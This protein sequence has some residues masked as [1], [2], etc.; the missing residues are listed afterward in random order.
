L[1][2]TSE[3]AA[4]EPPKVVDPQPGCRFRDRCPLAIDLC[5]QVTPA[6]VELEPGHAAA[7]HVA[8]S[9]AGVSAAP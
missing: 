4:G 2:V 7:C 5:S 8:A 6:L 3:M 9:D 1:T